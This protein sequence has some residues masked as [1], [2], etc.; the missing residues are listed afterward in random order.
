MRTAAAFALSWLLLSSVTYGE[1]IQVTI[2][3]GGYA[4]LQAHGQGGNAAGGYGNA[5]NAGNT[6]MMEQSSAGGGASYGGSAAVPVPTPAAQ[7]RALESQREVK[8]LLQS[9]MNR[10]RN[11]SRTVQSGVSLLTMG[12]AEMSLSEVESLRKHLGTFYESLGSAYIR[13]NQLEG[14]ASLLEGWFSDGGTEQSGSESGSSR[15]WT[16]PDAD[17]PS[18][19]AGGLYN[20][21][22]P[23]SG[24]LPSSDI[25]GLHLG[26]RGDYRDFLSSVNLA[27]EEMRAVW[28]EL[29]S[30]MHAQYADREGQ[31]YYFPAGNAYLHGGVYPPVHFYGLDAEG[32]FAGDYGGIRM[33]L[34]AGGLH[35]CT[36]W[37]GRFSGILGRYRSGA[38]TDSVSVAY[39]ED[40]CITHVGERN[41]YNVNYTS[42]N[43]RWRIYDRNNNLVHTEF[44]DNIEHIYR[45]EGLAEGTYRV[46]VDQEAVFDYRRDMTYSGCEYLVDTATGNILYFNEKGA[47]GNITLER[48]RV[49]GY[50]STGQTFLLTVQEGG[51][52]S[53]TEDP[54]TQRVR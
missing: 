1:D 38:L 12:T 18:N 28:K 4:D 32:R 13:G 46:L 40:T 2:T 23:G 37:I 15:T 24:A 22:A 5:D 7:G 25:S 26:N 27:D 52:A 47:V 48:E 17:D 51:D 16:A 6:G 3:E 45:I 53:L 35:D 14:Y 39:L 29:A 41:L 11:N 9:L 42:N 54:P 36:S 33:D 31:V 30:K 21:Q 8:R 20:S 10:A 44:T 50:V 43:R 49:S 19:R 34:V